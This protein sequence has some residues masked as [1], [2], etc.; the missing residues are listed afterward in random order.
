MDEGAG[1]HVLPRPLD[2]IWADIGRYAPRVAKGEPPDVSAVLGLYQLLS[3]AEVFAKFLVAVLAGEL[4]A[5]GGPELEQGKRPGE[6]PALGKWLEVARRLSTQLEEA[7]GPRTI[8][9]LVQITRKLLD[10]ADNDRCWSLPDASRVKN[11]TSL[12]NWI[13][14]SGVPS[15]AS[16][17]AVLEAAIGPFE[18]LLVEA[19]AAFA[20]ATLMLVDA[21]GK[22]AA[23]EPMLR[24]GAAPSVMTT[25][26]EL[27]DGPSRPG[28]YLCARGS[29][30]EISP[31]V[32][33]APP[34]SNGKGWAERG[35]AQRVLQVFVR[36]QG[37]VA[38]YVP[39]DPDAVLGVGERAEAAAYRERFTDRV[40]GFW[41]DALADDAH[42]VGREGQIDRVLE[43][44]R[45]GRDAVQNGRPSVAWWIFGTLG[46]G[47]SALASAAAVRYPASGSPPFLYAFRSGD[48]ERC[49]T[50]AFVRRALDEVPRLADEVEFDVND[51]SRARSALEARLRLH[52]PVIICDG[53][54]ELERSAYAD[55]GDVEALFDLVRHGGVWLFTSRHRPDARVHALLGEINQVF[56][57]GLPPM[58]SDELRL[59]A[60]EHA[61]A[62]VRNA[63]FMH[64][65]LTP[66]RALTNPWVQAIVETADGS[67]KYLALLLEWLAR[68]GTADEVRASINAAVRDPAALPSGLNELY[69]QLVQDWGLGVLTTMKTPLLCTIARA[70]EP[71]DAP[72][73]AEMLEHLTTQSAQ[74]RHTRCR[75]LLAVFAPVLAEGLD[76]D[77]RLGYRIDH[78]SFAGYL[79]DYDQ[80]KPDY[81][82]ATEEFA[83][84]AS[85]PSA[86]NDGQLQ[87]HLYRHG[88]AY[89]VGKRDADGAAS[90]LSDLTY[91]HGRL[92]CLS[93]GDPGEADEPAAG[94]EVDDLLK[95]YER[96][97]GTGSRLDG[98]QPVAAWA[99]VLRSH[100][101]LLRRAP[102]S[103]GR[104]SALVQVLVDHADEPAIR[105][106]VRAWREH[107][108][109]PPVHLVRPG[110]ANRPSGALVGT[111]GLPCIPEQA[112]VLARGD[113]AVVGQGGS[114]YAWHPGAGGGSAR[115]LEDESGLNVLRLPGDRVLRWGN[116]Y[117]FRVTDL[118]TGQVGPSLQM[119]S[120]RG[121]A[122]EIRSGGALLADPGPLVTWCGRFIAI[123]QPDSGELLTELAGHEHPI[124][125][126]RALAHGR[127]ASGSADALKVWALG[128][129][130]HPAWETAGGWTGIQELPNAR[131]LAWRPEVAQ[132]FDAESGL[133]LDT[134]QWRDGF[135]SGACA[136][137]DERLALIEGDRLWAWA[138]GSGDAPRPLRARR[139]PGAP[140][141]GIRKAL[142][143]RAE[144]VATVQE[145]S[146][147]VH[148]WDLAEMAETSSLQGHTGPVV[149][150][151]TLP[152]GRLVSWS[153][154]RMLRIWDLDSRGSRP[155][156]GHTDEVMGAACLPDG[157]L[158]SWGSDATLR[159]WDLS[160]PAD[161]PPPPAVAASA[162][163]ASLG[164]DRL[165]SWAKGKTITLWD[166]S[167]GGKIQALS[168]HH[169]PVSGGRAIDPNTVA[170][171]A[172]DRTVLLWDTKGRHVG[173]AGPADGPI[174]DV[175][176]CPEGRLAV[177][178]PDAVEVWDPRRRHRV[179]RWSA[180]GQLDGMAA[181][182]DGRLV[183]WSEEAQTK[184]WRPRDVRVRGQVQQLT[185]ADSGRP[186][187]RGVTVLDRTI[188]LAWT[189]EGV[190]RLWDIATGEQICWYR[191]PGLEEPGIV[192]LGGGCFATW[193]RGG[194]SSLWNFDIVVCDPHTSSSRRLVGHKDWIAGLCA[195][196][197][198]RLLSWSYD[199][200]VRI[201]DPGT[202]AE[203]ARNRHVAA[204]VHAV[205]MSSGRIA[206]W[207]A[208][209][210]VIVWDRELR[211]VL[212]CALYEAPLAGPP[213]PMPTGSLAWNV[214]RQ[215][216]A[217][218]VGPVLL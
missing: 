107:F 210:S 102:I 51:P 161:K 178:G 215:P 196:T 3:G 187:A 190:A 28:L 192:S 111:L 204:V 71:L 76:A 80:T 99:R 184:L 15:A 181:V 74:D 62:E 29:S 33:F 73:L 52:R 135:L 91:L 41:S 101:H 25:D 141:F 48:A 19:G 79:A 163:L 11:L 97:S 18:S 173:G 200:T 36:L 199:G 148:L 4:A 87:R 65:S 96:V 26:A 59:M 127:L 131:L 54:D 44:L 21:E 37:G 162:G 193:C 133:T 83:K 137:P 90:L 5:R 70:A 143:V 121:E 155:L 177:R 146:R 55:P 202:G 13:A 206:G 103:W 149:G 194:L 188:V 7:G 115:R 126:V 32:R 169:A 134:L 60:W 10:L 145:P 164:R 150:I 49:R 136:L 38:Q 214:G 113:V 217:V 56:E 110:R 6:H 94:A 123:W 211:Q 20:E 61:L 46:R 43:C 58:D 195:L 67:P 203:L 129:P 45:A 31:I 78:D 132:V 142:A 1:Q 72:A 106:A 88:I 171:W 40:A 119:P 170:T 108:G 152:D 212:G 12:R 63:I 93:P 2:Y 117:V 166:A 207:S 160:A 100:A 89:L 104:G 151:M 120:S 16:G 124:S 112:C 165:V 122:G 158:I 114:L 168:G 156:W 183:L 39:L 172:E 201:W 50:R 27:A 24:Y 77:G 84:Q 34:G 213:I 198:N 8:P 174:L 14:H 138:P 69:G 85:R 53:V 216:P 68:K 47:K 130:A 179:D 35:R 144:L 128:E 218:L 154:D 175:L 197:E 57:D 189:G 157:R 205:G 86:I 191:D 139:K 92:Q 167:T 208:D 147:S 82:R 186:G 125:D 116:D 159:L 66:E 176:A 42:F 105:P 9:G 118:A 23:T 185:A 17:A 22:V 209:G 182:P 75:E 180:E 81:D 98:P 140:R 64:D 109:E 30:V 95:D 153:E